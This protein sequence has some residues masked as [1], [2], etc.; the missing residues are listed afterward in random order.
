MTDKTGET[1]K[2]H[3]TFTPG[4]EASLED[5]PEQY[6]DRVSEILDAVGDEDTT[7]IK[8]D[9]GSGKSC[10]E[11]QVELHFHIGDSHTTNIHI[12][13]NDDEDDVEGILS[14]LLG[15]DGSDESDGEE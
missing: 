8:Q 4:G 6:R 3:L 2:E 1:D 14:R 9:G 7:L 12:T 11:A 10:N 15:R 5:V 13:T